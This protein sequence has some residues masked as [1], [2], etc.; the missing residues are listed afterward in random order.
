MSNKMTILYHQ[1]D[2]QHRLGKGKVARNLLINEKGKQAHTVSTDRV[3]SFNRPVIVE[4][5]EALALAKAPDPDPM[6]TAFLMAV[7]S[8]DIIPFHPGGQVPPEMDQLE[9]QAAV[10][11]TAPMAMTWA[12][13][14][15]KAKDV[16]GQRYRLAS[17]AMLV[18]M[19]AM[20]LIAFWFA[21]GR[22]FST[23]VLAS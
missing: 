20:A 10:A 5:I 16:A 4:T 14:D 1:A 3:F 11:A 23:Q 8:S 7:E 15:D 9:H 13:N 22:D 12:E 2:R 18:I 6:T 21:F 17:M 19:S